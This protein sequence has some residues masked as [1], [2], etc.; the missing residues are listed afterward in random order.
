MFLYLA[1][2]IDFNSATSKM[3]TGFVLNEIGCMVSCQ[4][5]LLG[6]VV[7]HQST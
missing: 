3:S 5:I 2:K 1:F 7:K 4:N 6:L